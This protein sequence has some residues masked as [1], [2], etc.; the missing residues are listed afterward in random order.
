MS[1]TAKV[2]ELTLSEFL[3]ARIAE[4][5]REVEDW[6]IEGNWGLHSPGQMW[7]DS[8]GRPIYAPRA[9]VLAECEAKRAAVDIAFDHMSTIDGE[10]G[11]CH[12]PDRIRAGECPGLHPDHDDLL[13]ALASVY[14]DHP[15]F[16]PEW[17]A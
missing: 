1:E 9:R 2:T 16:R 6:P 7:V 14:S 5:E 15:E 11:C 10:W 3:L 4:D 12:G 17:S 8:I 13:R